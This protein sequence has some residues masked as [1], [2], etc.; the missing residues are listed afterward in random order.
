[1]EP[2]RTR[3]KAEEGGYWRK[4]MMMAWTKV[5]VVI[6]FKY[7]QKDLMEAMDEIT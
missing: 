4:E 3:G 2:S 6:K 5:Q 1:M 7:D